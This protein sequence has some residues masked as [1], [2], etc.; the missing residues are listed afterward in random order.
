MTADYVG[1][2]FGA[3][4]YYGWTDFGRRPARDVDLLCE[5]RAAAGVDTK[6]MLDLGRPDS[7]GEAIQMARLI[8]GSGAGIFWWEEPLCSSDDLDN[9]AELRLRTDVAIAAGEREITAYACAGLIQRR[10]VDLLQP[11]LTWVG[12]LTEGRRIAEAARLAHLPW[13]PHCWGTAL[14]FAAAVHWVA[15]SP[16][17]FLCEYPIT[18]R[19]AS[20]RARGTASPVMTELVRD[21]VKIVDGRAQVPTGPGLGVELDEDA[22]RRHEIM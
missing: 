10:A 18:P 5:I 21:P 13:V 1:E 4:K 19:T 6:L 3:I 14:H 22:V 9:L 17:G 12:G 11:D 15:A 7:L 20:T 2:G 16:D 8:E